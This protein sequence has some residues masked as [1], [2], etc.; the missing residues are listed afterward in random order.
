MPVWSPDGRWIA[1]SSDRDAPEVVQAANRSGD[2]FRTA[3]HLMH[4]DGSDERRV[5]DVGVWRFPVS[6]TAS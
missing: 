5:T 4:A 3:I 1:F 6:W 2:R